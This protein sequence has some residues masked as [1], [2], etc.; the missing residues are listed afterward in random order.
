MADTLSSWSPV[1][2]TLAAASGTMTNAEDETDNFL[3]NVA[4]D[5]LPQVFVKLQTSPRQLLRLWGM[6]TGAS[7]I[8]AC[9]CSVAN[10]GAV[11][12]NAADRLNDRLNSELCQSLLSAIE[13]I[14]THASADGCGA[15]RH[16]QCGLL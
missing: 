12:C 16:H 3:Q 8:T 9:V 6:R 10:S 11:A 14:C 7:C 2:A 1:R 5:P 13:V 4:H 15:A